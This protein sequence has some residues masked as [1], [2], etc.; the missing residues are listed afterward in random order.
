MTSAKRNFSLTPAN[1][2]VNVA[3]GISIFCLGLFFKLAH[4]EELNQT[5]STTYATSTAQAILKVQPDAIY[6]LLQYALALNGIPY[7]R[8]GNSPESG[9]DCSGFVRHVFEHSEGV[10]LPHSAKA[11]SQFGARVK[12][13]ELQPGD[14]VFFHIV[15][16]TIS[17]VGIYLGKN[18]FIHASSIHTGGV[19]ISDITN[20][21]WIKR[22]TL[23]RRLNYPVEYAAIY[24]K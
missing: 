15:R 9:F 2:W 22:F 5:F 6:N 20:D 23:A 3:V 21:Y 18:L 10:M 13:S 8:G 24:P 4:A 1:H 16:H 14:L 12:I 7:H 17:H 19:K 11:I